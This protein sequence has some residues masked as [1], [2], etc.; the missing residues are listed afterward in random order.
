MSRVRE[1]AAL[2]VSNG[3]FMMTTKNRRITETETDL[4]LRLKIP[5]VNRGCPSFE[6]TLCEGSA[7]LDRSTG[8]VLIRDRHWDT[9]GYHRKGFVLAC[10]LCGETLSWVCDVIHM[11]ACHLK[12]GE[13][14]LST[15]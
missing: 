12:M 9:V 10:I 13:I 2:Q 4:L 15:E 8:H 1:M 3:H 6:S 14:Q 11:G 7:C 5:R